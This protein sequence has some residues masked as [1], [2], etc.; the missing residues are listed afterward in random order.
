MFGWSLATS[1]HKLVVGAPFD[2]K[3]RGSIMVDDGVRI[4]GP[5]NGMFGVGVDLNKQFM[6]VDGW[7]PASVYVYQVDR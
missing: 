5:R 3:R 2:N 4:Y 1:H 6:V 7:N